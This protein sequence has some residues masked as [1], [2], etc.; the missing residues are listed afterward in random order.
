MLIVCILLAADPSPEDVKSYIKSLERYRPAKVE[1]LLTYAAKLDSEAKKLKRK[2]ADEKLTP[3]ELG[4]KVR[5]VTKEASDV[6]TQAKLIANG[7]EVPEI[8]LNDGVGEIG[9]LE[10]VA[11]FQV[12]DANNFLARRGD[13]Y[14]YIETSTAGLIDGQGIDLGQ[15]VK[16]VGTKQYTTL[17]GGSNT[18]VHLKT[19]GDKLM[20]ML[21]VRSE[22]KK[23][24][25]E[26][27]GL[28]E[29]D[30]EAVESNIKPPSEAKPKTTTKPRRSKVS[31]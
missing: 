31:Q 5:K 23:M 17:G 12:V 11:V 2:S 6:R 20:F 19:I 9:L 24:K 16:I 27:R 7:T 30:I 26:G 28:S 13:Q 10:E 4:A 29:I 18:V 22:L 8:M 14:L 15:F 1:Q 3:K 25:D 21:A